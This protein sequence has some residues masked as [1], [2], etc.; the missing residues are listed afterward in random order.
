MER[1]IYF[2]SFN[3]IVVFLQF[4]VLL[5][6]INQEQSTKQMCTRALWCLANHNLQ[7]SIILP[8]VS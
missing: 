3:D 8:H 4:L 7:N 1:D 6:V 2:V 5:N